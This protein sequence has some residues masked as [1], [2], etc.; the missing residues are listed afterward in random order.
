MRLP[1]DKYRFLQV[2][3]NV[4]MMPAGFAG[5]VAGLYFTHS[6][7]IAVVIGF[8]FGIPTAFLAGWAIYMLGHML[9]DLLDRWFR[10]ME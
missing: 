5:F 10:P 7:W 4:L 1:A 3:T 2:L 9:V 8:A 6:I